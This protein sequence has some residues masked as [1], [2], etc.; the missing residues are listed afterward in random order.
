MKNYC[1]YHPTSWLLTVLGGRT[2]SSVGKSQLPIPFRRFA[3]D[4]PRDNSFT[5][6]FSVPHVFFTFQFSLFVYSGIPRYSHVYAALMMAW[7]FGQNVTGDDPVRTTE[8]TVSTGYHSPRVLEAI[9]HSGSC[10]LEGGAK[11]VPNHVCL[12]L[13]CYRVIFCAY[14]TYLSQ[15]IAIVSLILTYCASR[16]A[17]STSP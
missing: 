5:L 10:A 17:T 11:H 16:P 14:S 8:N 15:C 1:A 7:R 6:E 3:S 9:N 2:Y 4:S 12:V 13:P